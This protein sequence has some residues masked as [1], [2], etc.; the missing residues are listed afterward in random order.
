MSQGPGSNENAGTTQVVDFGEARSQRLDE[1]RRKTERIFFKQLLSVYCVTDGENSKQATMRAIDPIDISEDG[2]SFQVP[3]N[4]E[5]P[6][7]TSAD[8]LAI[9]LYFSQDTY[10]PVHLKIVNSK[11]CIENGVRYVRYGCSVDKALSSYSA[12]QQFVRFLKAYA[13]HAHKDMGDVTLFYL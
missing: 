6:W 5:N 13:E 12:Y 1:K 9:R 2:F 7:P 10:L 8:R 11:P 4:T 3:H